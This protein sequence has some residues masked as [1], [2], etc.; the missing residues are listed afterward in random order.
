[1]PSHIGRLA[2]EA[3]CRQSVEEVHRRVDSL[4]QNIAGNAFAFIMLLA[5]PTTI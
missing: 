3:M 4:A 1:M 2:I 5:M